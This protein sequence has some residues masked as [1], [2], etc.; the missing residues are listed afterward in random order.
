MGRGQHDD[1]SASAVDNRPPGPVPR[2][3]MAVIIWLAIYPALTITLALLAPVL[4]PLPLFLRTLVVTALLVPIMV[5]VLLPTMQ[6]L[7]ATWLRPG[8][9]TEAQPAEAGAAPPG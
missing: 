7:F 2:Y 8:E 9:A 1:E 3:K 5:Y 6:R 4:N